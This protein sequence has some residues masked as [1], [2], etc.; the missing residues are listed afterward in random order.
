[1]LLSRFM[2]LFFLLILSS[3]AGAS[4]LDNAIPEKFVVQFYKS[5]LS[6]DVDEADIFSGKYIDDK[7]L[8][9]INLS[10]LCNYDSEE[11][12]LSNAI[13]TKCS[14]Q[15]ECKI[16]K[17]NY[18]CNWDGVWVENDVNYFTKSQDI[19]PSWRNKIR[20]K[21]IRGKA[22][23]ATYAV[24]FGDCTDVVKTLYVS[25]IRK[26]SGWKIISVTE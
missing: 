10:S 24:T 25:L 21:K 11:K 4:A 2:A 26:A 13:K 19:Y 6:E 8:A 5:I 17:G 20:L 3:N 16:N 14:T 1:M 22:N 15:R 23:Y 12:E 7:L 18:R 9:S